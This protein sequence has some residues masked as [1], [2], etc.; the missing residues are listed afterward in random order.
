MTPL[1]AICLGLARVCIVVPVI[2]SFGS[3]GVLAAMIQALATGSVDPVIMSFC[4][5]EGV[6]FYSVFFV[7]FLFCGYCFRLVSLTA[8]DCCYWG[9]M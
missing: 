9:V 6:A 4:F 8:V 3:R 5:W 7:F 1:T 2:M